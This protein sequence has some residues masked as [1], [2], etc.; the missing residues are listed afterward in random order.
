V[1]SLNNYSRIQRQDPPLRQ[2]PIYSLAKSV[3]FLGLAAI[4]IACGS[5]K[6]AD[7]Q[8]GT[9]FP[10]TKV[11]TMDVVTDL[12]FVADIRAVQNVEIRAR[13]NGYLEKILVD[14][15][16]PVKKGQVLFMINDEEYQ[17][18][19]KSAQA[20]LKS[21]E[22]E[23]QS[24]QVERERVKM[25]VQKQVIANTEMQIAD[26]K[27]D[28]ALAHIEQAKARQVAASV[29]LKNTLLVSPFDGVID[30]IPYR[31]GSLISEGTL[32][33]TLSDLSATH[34]YFKVSETDYLRYVKRTPNSMDTLMKIR[35]NLVLA[36]GMDYPGAGRIET[37]ENEFEEGTGVL[38]VRALFSNPDNLLRHGST[39]RVKLRRKID[40]AIL[41]PMKSVVE[42][43]D[44]YYVFVVDKNHVAMMKSFVPLQR[45]ENFYI[46]GSGLET[47]ELIVYEGVENLREGSVVRTVERTVSEIYPVA[48]GK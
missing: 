37:I 26:A 34:V 46:V 40:D 17:A 23:L 28:I 14:E 20:D 36:D 19:L 29:K 2:N 27:V 38:A 41:I 18:M 35:V 5:P 6:K 45:Y 48:T 1:P 7:E 25:L 16:K 44:K 13:V 4:A 33:T 3:F 47:G 30:R 11:H 8:Q 9:E 24:A 43:Q 39:G 32:L 12:F 31:L 10:V 21:A 42:I 22:A 15:G